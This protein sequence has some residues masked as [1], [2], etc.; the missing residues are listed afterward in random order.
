M[1]KQNKQQN[2]QNAIEQ[3]LFLKTRNGNIR[4]TGKQ[5]PAKAEEGYC[6]E[7]TQSG[8]LTHSQ[9]HQAQHTAEHEEVKHRQAWKKEEIREVI[10]CYMYCSQHFT[11]NYKKIWRRRN[12]E[13]RIY[14]DAKKLMNQKNCIMKHNKITEMK[15]EE[16]KR[17]LQASQRSHQERKGKG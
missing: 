11:E 16:I 4:S 5:N 12:P 7:A 13:C 15:I 14:T 1:E 8:P 17:E 3:R 9:G 2:Q 10:W 6:N